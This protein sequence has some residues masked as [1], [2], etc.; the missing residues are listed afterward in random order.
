[1]SRRRSKT[2]SPLD[3]VATA[4]LGLRRT[5]MGLLVG[6]ALCAVLGL[7]LH[8]A[9]PGSLGSRSYLPAIFST[10]LLTFGFT[11]RNTMATPALNELRRNHQEA[12]ALTRWV[13]YSTL[14]M[15]LCAAVAL[16]GF[17][18]QLMGGA[19]TICL[20]MYAI[21]AAYLFLLGPVRP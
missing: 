3:R 13:R 20:V 10:V 1:M 9:E 18:M 5:Q 4:Y 11:T 2:N 15:G 21:A 8:H 7:A 6:V 12:A 19:T 17:G 16:I 14:A